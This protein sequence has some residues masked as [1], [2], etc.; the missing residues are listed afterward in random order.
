VTVTDIRP[1]AA[2]E[3]EPTRESERVAELQEMI[4]SGRY[5]GYLAEL[6]DELAKAKAARDEVRHVTATS[7]LAA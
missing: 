5:S 7:T 2:G 4:R 3:S 1:A 6:R